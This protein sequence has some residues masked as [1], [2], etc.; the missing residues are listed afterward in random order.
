MTS[1]SIHFWY[2]SSCRARETEH[3]SGCTEKPMTHWQHLDGQ[4]RLFNKQKTLFKKPVLHLK[5]FQIVTSYEHRYYRYGL[6]S[7]WPPPPVHS[8]DRAYYLYFNY[9]ESIS[10]PP[11]NMS[12]PRNVA[13][14]GVSRCLFS[15]MIFSSIVFS[16]DFSKKEQCL[17]HPVSLSRS[18][19]DT[20]IPLYFLIQ[21][22]YFIKKTV[23][24]RQTGAGNVQT[25]SI[26][27]QITVSPLESSRNTRCKLNVATFRF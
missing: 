16:P 2:F 15:S 5:K 12:R 1:Q 23:E 25:Y 19:R 26:Q 20:I 8:R 7:L 3:K 9:W 13:S 18:E 17:A 21:H 22:F 10:F 11:V 6:G 14:F 24:R 4:K 27:Y